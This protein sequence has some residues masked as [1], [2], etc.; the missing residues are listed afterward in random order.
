[1]YVCMYACNNNTLSCYLKLYV[2]II[3]IYYFLKIRNAWP[4]LYHSAQEAL[5]M[6]YVTFRKSIIVLL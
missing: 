5:A 3:I 4:H 6:T 1:M 2:I